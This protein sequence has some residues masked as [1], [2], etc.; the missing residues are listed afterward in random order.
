M[1][2]QVGHVDEYNEK[3]EDCESYLECLEQWTFAN[4]VEDE[5]K[6]CL[7][8]SVIGANAYKLLKNL[9]SLRVP[10][11]MQYSYLT[12]A[13]SAHC[14]PEPVVIAEWFRF[15]KPKQREGYAVSEY[16]VALRQLS[17]T[18]KFGQYLDEALRDCFV[19]GLHSDAVQCWLLSEKDLTFP[20]ACVKD[21]SCIFWTQ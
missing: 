18:Y 20:K 5:K 17:A 2:L 15:Q 10:S 13:L 16:V 4:E 1:A 9:V 14:K 12:I 19:S 8:L 3:E 21:C 6:V 11:T 7:F